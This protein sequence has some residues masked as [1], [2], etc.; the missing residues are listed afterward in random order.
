MP[1]NTDAKHSAN[2]YLRRDLTARVQDIAKKLDVSAS[3]VVSMC[4]DSCLPAIEKLPAAMEKR[5][6]QK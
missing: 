5:A 6:C 3:A 2:Y 1:G 4:L